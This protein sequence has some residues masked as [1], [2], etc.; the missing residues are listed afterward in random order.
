LPH[1]APRIAP[2]EHR[3]GQRRVPCRVDH[4][5]AHVALAQALDVLIALEQEAAAPER[6]VDPG[7]AQLDDVH[8]G[9][10]VVD[11]NTLVH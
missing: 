3:A 1:R 11:G 5:F 2:C 9:T 7:P 8:P 10:Q 6:M 4:H